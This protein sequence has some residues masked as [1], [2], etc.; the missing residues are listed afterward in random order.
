MQSGGGHICHPHCSAAHVPSRE[1][2]CGML[3]VGDLS[4]ECIQPLITQRCALFWGHLYDQDKAGMSWDA[5]VW[6]LSK[7]LDSAPPKHATDILNPSTSQ[8]PVIWAACE[9][10]A[11]LTRIFSCLSTSLLLCDPCFSTFLT[12]ADPTALYTPLGGLLLLGSLKPSASLKNDG[13]Q[14]QQILLSQNCVGSG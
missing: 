6:Y 11:E 8:Q 9:Q 13:I 12:E 10:V 7:Y 1:I 14:Q 5:A 3:L 2:I 4:N